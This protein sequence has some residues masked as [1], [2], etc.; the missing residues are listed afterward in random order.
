MKY[1][2]WGFTDSGKG[3]TNRLAKVNG[4]VLAN[5]F[6]YQI[7]KIYTTVNINEKDWFD[8]T[9]TKKI[10]HDNNGL[11]TVSRVENRIYKYYNYQT[12]P[13]TITKVGSLK[14]LR[15][16]KWQKGVYKDA[17]NITREQKLKY[18]DYDKYKNTTIYYNM[19]KDHV[20]ESDVNSV[21]VFRDMKYSF[22]EL[23]S[24]IN[25]YMDD[26][27]LANSNLLHYFEPLKEILQ[28]K[29][30]VNIIPYKTNLLDSFISKLD[31]FYNF[32][33]NIEFNQDLFEV[34]E[35]DKERIWK[36]L[37][38][39]LVQQNF[40]ID[41]FKTENIPYVYFNL[42]EDKYTDLFAGWDDLRSRDCTHRKHTWKNV[43]EDEKC[44]YHKVVDIAKE[45]MSVRNPKPLELR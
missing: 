40:L 45:Y 16:K 1:F 35:K 6:N 21:N 22:D 26:V 42:D 34:Y 31:G 7:I 36:W 3:Y 44:K 37:D 19:A 20:M 18:I 14:V 23:K 29:N 43:K 25:M 27:D 17:I 8:F 39:Y 41:K 5:F 10:I 38:Y 28:N 32:N 15:K 11:K 24:K 33:L 9:Q 30:S 4:K 13:S 2:Y 12:S